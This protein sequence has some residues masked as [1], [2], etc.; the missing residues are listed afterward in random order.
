MNN[1]I[2][3]YEL[4][5]MEVGPDRVQLLLRVEADDWTATTEVRAALAGPKNAVARTA[6]AEHPFEPV[7]VEDEEP[8]VRSFALSIPD[9]AL[10]SPASPSR[11]EGA[12][13]LWEAGQL[14]DSTPLHYAV[15]VLSWE[16]DRVFVNDEPLTPNLREVA[17]LDEAVARRLRKEGVNV[18]LLPADQA[19]A[20]E[21]ADRLG[22]FLMGM[23]PADG[24]LPAD[25]MDRSVRPCCLGWVYSSPESPLPDEPI[26]GLFGL[27]SSEPVEALP[28]GMDF[29]LLD[30]P[31]DLAGDEALGYPWLA[32]SE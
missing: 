21:L 27:R 28:E 22:L 8:G 16:E 17:A 31:P 30:A 26:P 4:V 10:W 7:E 15:Y 25:L 23:L 3:S 12:L 11:Y 9:P 5:E 6:E 24:A 2:A 14:V 1:R 29:L 32:Q 18:V 20:W 19:A 13:E